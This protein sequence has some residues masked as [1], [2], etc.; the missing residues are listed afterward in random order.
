MLDQQRMILLISCEV[1]G[2]GVFN[3]DSECIITL[4]QIE[5]DAVQDTPGV[6]VDNEKGLIQCVNQNTVGR[7]R[8]N[9]F[10]GEQFLAQGLAINT[11]GFCYVE[12][13]TLI[14]VCQRFEL[15]GFLIVITTGAYRFRKCFLGHCLHALRGEQSGKVSQG[16]FN[17]LSVG[18]LRQDRTDH[19]FII[20]FSWPPG[21]FAVVVL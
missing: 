9:A 2:N 14:P 12:L 6:T 8:A 21:Q 3:H 11:M 19:H 15:D 1:T 10:Y 7:F 5:A 16:F 18:I 13:I 4:W 20:R 17:I